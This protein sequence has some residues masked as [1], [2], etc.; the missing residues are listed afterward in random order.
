MSRNLTQRSLAQLGEIDPVEMV[1]ESNDVGM[2]MPTPA[3][4]KPRAAIPDAGQDRSAVKPDLP[5]GQMHAD[6][7]HVHPDPLPYVWSM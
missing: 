7:E 6:P 1:M 5:D 2:L 4:V 3:D